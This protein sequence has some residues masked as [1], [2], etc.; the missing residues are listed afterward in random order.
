MPTMSTTF[1]R[2]CPWVRV[3]H[4]HVPLHHYKGC[5]TSPVTVIP[6]A[7]SMVDTTKLMWHPH[8]CL[9]VLILQ[10][11]TECVDYSNHTTLLLARSIDLSD[12]MGAVL[13]SILPLR[14]VVAA[15]FHIVWRQLSVLSMSHVARI[16]P[17]HAALPWRRHSDPTADL[18]HWNVRI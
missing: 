10:S 13:S 15:V 11:P 14:L 7:V 8:N 1:C 2:S 9:W 3:L 18:M 4:L 6:T 12:V 16:P 17:M 5:W